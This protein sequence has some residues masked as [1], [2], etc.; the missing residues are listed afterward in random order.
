MEKKKLSLMMSD[1]LRKGKDTGMGKIT[2][3]ERIPKFTCGRKE[4]DSTSTNRQVVNIH[5]LF[6]RTKPVGCCATKPEEEVHFLC[7]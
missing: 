2:R 5:I 4:G 7:R 1:L 6:C 3:K